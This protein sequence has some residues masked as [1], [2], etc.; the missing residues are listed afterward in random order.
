MPNTNAGGSHNHAFTVPAHPA[1]SLTADEVT[2]LR[3]LIVP[4]VIIPGPPP[5]PTDQPAGALQAIL[6]AASPGA[7]VDIQLGIYHELVTFAKPGVFRFAPGSVITGDKTRTEWVRIAAPNVEIDDL[8]CRDAA[9]GTHQ[10]GSFSTSGAGRDSF[11]GRRL[12]LVGGQ[13]TILKF[14]DSKGHRFY[15][16]DLS[17]CPESLFSFNKANDTAFIGGRLHDA[18]GTLPGFNA[19]DEGGA[20]KYGGW[21]STAANLGSSGMVFDGVEVD[22]IVGRGLWGDIVANDL[23]V[24]GCRIHDVQYDGVMFEISA[25]ATITGNVVWRCGRTSPNWGYGAG[26]LIASAREAKITGNLVYDC[27]RGIS[28]L[29]QNRSTVDYA[30]NP[31]MTGVTMTDNTVIAKNP[32]DALIGY[33]R[34]WADPTMDDGTN[35]ASGNRFWHPSAEGTPG[36]RFNFAP[37]PPNQYGGAYAR[38]ADFMAKMGDQSSRYL[39]TA[40][41]DAELAAAGIA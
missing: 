23:T 32:G 24:R 1:D 41:K 22:H 38:L 30:Y 3:A 39:T 35:R 16:C 12:I 36:N 21:A 15:D 6:N 13:A 26:I 33:F 14:Q 29:S 2:K 37:P 34:D 7:T 20:G 28:A 17:G 10:A 9:I 27:P 18:L 19:G 31:G 11:V 5:Q 25:R 4:P 8:T 40:E